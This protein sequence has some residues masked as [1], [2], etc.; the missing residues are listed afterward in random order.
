MP[1]IDRSLFDC[2]YAWCVKHDSLTA[3][4]AAVRAL[5]VETTQ[6][7]LTMFDQRGVYCC[8]P[9]DRAGGGGGEESYSGS[10]SGRMLLA[11]VLHY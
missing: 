2:R 1:A 5:P 10:A 3:V 9:S 8:A 6:A 7:V 11:P 4:P